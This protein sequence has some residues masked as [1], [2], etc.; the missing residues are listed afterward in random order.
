MGIRPAEQNLAP[1][2]RASMQPIAPPK[3]LR[4]GDDHAV[5]PDLTLF[6]QTTSKCAACRTLQQA[7]GVSINRRLHV[8]RA[9]DLLFMTVA[10]DLHCVGLPLVARRVTELPGMT[11]YQL[12]AE[13]PAGGKCRELRPAAGI[14]TLA[15][16]DGYW[17]L[18]AV[19]QLHGAPTPHGHIYAATELKD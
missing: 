5:D 7:S 12:L 17:T 10:D 16:R 18:K 6:M 1:A 4:T 8:R 14:V 2:A 15:R 13:P 3:V 11:L 9:G 19:G